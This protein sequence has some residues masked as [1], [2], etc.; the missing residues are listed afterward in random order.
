MVQPVFRLFAE[1][2]LH[3]YYAARDQLG[4]ELLDAA[5]RVIPT[6]AINI[7]DYSAD[8][9]EEGFE[10]EV[11]LQDPSGWAAAVGAA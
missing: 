6:Q 5:G 10:V 3:R 4:L 1:G 2:H 11:V 9:G 7:A 8:A